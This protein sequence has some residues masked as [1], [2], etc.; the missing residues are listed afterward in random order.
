MLDYGIGQRD[1]PLRI[2]LLRRAGRS[3]EAEGLAAE[4]AAKTGRWREAAAYYRAHDRL[5]EAARLYYQGKAWAD[6]AECY[7][8]CGRWARAAQCYRRTQAW[9]D[10]AQCYRENR[11]WEEA[12][13]CYANAEAWTDAATCHRTI[14][15]WADA[16]ACYRKAGDDHA[17]AEC[18][19]RIDAWGQAADCYA[20]AGASAWATMCRT[21]ARHDT[22]DAVLT[23][24]RHA[25]D[26][27][28]APVAAFL[29]RRKLHEETDEPLLAAW[30]LRCAGRNPQASLAAPVIQTEENR[31][32]AHVQRRGLVRGGRLGCGGRR[33]AR[34]DAGHRAAARGIAAAG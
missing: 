21:M 20:S 1:I 9:L 14:G 32:R 3:E 15:A 16:A 31:L 4:H 22:A 28:S 6:A 13:V 11:D 33:A 12:A 26:P 24:L 25:Y 23:T 8:A 10:A 2:R 30:L 17:A 18:Y 29:V 5:A 19:R 7:Q 34:E 27:V